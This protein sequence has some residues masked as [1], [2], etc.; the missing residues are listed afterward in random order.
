MYTIVDFLMKYYAL[1]SFKE[2]IKML[3]HAGGQFN[4]MKA[5]GINNVDT[6]LHTAVKLKAL[7][8][9]KILL[10]SGASIACL[11]KAGQTPLHVCVLNKLE[12][13][14]QASIFYLIS[15]RNFEN[16]DISDHNLLL[17]FFHVIF[18]FVLTF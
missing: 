9:I 8:T 16:C 12:A 15:I 3:L 17:H 18:V 6:L 4:T 13:P 1:P 14:L 5:G 2:I 7:D 10:S 11:N